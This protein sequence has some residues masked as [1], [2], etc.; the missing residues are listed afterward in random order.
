MKPNNILLTPNMDP[1]I[2]DF[3]LE[4]LRLG[5][6][7]STIYKSTSKREEPIITRN[8][9]HHYHQ[10]NNLYGYVSPYQAPESIKTSKSNPKWDVY[11]F[12][13]I[14]L[15][16][17]SG[18][19]FSDKELAQWNTDSMIADMETKILKQGNQSISAIDVHGS[20]KDCLLKCIE[21]GFSCASLVPHMRPSMKE[22]LQVLEKI[23]WTS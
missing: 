13:I 8:Y 1:V 19:F 7:N 18:K 5:K 17:F 20:R 15:E 12:G 4:W 9:H 3:G 16:L 21:L 6:I 2:S 10:T 22:V 14:L 23:S 11:S